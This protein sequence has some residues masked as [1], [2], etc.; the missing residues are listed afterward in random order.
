[1]KAKVQKCAS[2]PQKMSR[3]S[4][5]SR[6]AAVFS[7]FSPSSTCFCLICLLVPN[8]FQPEDYHLSAENPNYKC[9]QGKSRG[10]FFFFSFFYICLMCPN[11]LLF[12]MQLNLPQQSLLEPFS[13]LLSFVIQYGI[14]SLSYL[15]ELCGLCYKA[16]NKVLTRACLRQSYGAETPADSLR[17][18]NLAVLKL[19]SQMSA[20]SSLP[21][22]SC[23]ATPTSPTRNVAVCVS[24]MIKYA[25]SQY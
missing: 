3:L 7:F 6:P 11:P 5:P 14:F 23:G 12:N 25:I 21:H 17:K 22:H 4:H 24:T 16:F 15:V 20:G 13:K 19:S 1:M 9:N 18:T 10:V 8:G 2:A